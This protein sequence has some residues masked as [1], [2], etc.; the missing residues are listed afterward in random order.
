MSVIENFNKDWIKLVRWE[1]SDDSQ[2]RQMSL[3]F[4]AGKEKDQE[5]TR[6][7]KQDSEIY[8]GRTLHV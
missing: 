7:S 3:T 4:K 2:A 6:N 8:R 1:P 5:K